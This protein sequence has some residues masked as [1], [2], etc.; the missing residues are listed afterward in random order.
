MCSIGSESSYQK[1]P[2]STRRKPIDTT[3]SGAAVE[4]FVFPETALPLV[5]RPTVEGIDLAEW[6]LSQKLLVEKHL[7]RYGAILFRGFKI[8][9]AKRFESFVGAASSRGMQ[10]KERSSPRTQIAD[11]IYTSTDYP[12]DES[13]FPHNEHS[14]ASTFRCACSFAVKLLLNREDRHRSRTPAGSCNAFL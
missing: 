3:K 4:E 14:Y 9:S 1:T 7:A 8:D 6:V 13:I 5:V 12:A 10:Y 2:R 11:R